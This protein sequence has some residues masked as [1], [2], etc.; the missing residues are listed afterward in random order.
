MSVEYVRIAEEEDGEAIE[1]PTETDGTII[2]SSVNGVL[3]ILSFVC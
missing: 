1:I 3:F 2:L